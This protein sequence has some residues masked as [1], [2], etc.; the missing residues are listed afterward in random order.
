L[1]SLES[2]AAAIESVFPSIKWDR[3]THALASLD[4]YTGIFFDFGEVETYSW[5]HVSVSGSCDP[6]PFL[7]ALATANNWIVLDVQ[8]G[9]FIDPIDPSRRGWRGYRSLVE[10]IGR[11]KSSEG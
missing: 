8:S 11:G 6:I 9:D 5:V 3:P 10:G 4:G 7:L 2:V 1:G